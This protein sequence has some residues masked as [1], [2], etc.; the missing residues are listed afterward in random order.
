MVKRFQVEAEAAA[1]LHHPHIASIHETGECEGHHF[2]SMELVEG[3]GLDRRVTEYQLPA[4]GTLTSESKTAAR[5]RQRSIARL[6]ATV[7]RAVDYAHQRGVLHRDLKP[8]NI[9]IGRD[10]EPH[11]VDFGLAKLVNEEVARFDIAVQ[12]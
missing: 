1:S 5:Q 7:A 11:L 6:M 2:Y 4:A 8:S 9:L 10:G 12:H 3:A